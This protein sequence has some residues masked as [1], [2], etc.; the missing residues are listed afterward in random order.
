MK[1]LPMP[2]TTRILVFASL[3]F[4]CLSCSGGNGDSRSEKNGDSEKQLKSTESA[5]TSVS[6]DQAARL[7]NTKKDLLVIDVRSPR[8]LRQGRI[9]GSILIPFWNI[10]KGNHNLP[11][12][13][14]LLLVCAVGGRSFAVGQYLVRTGYEEIYN[15]S[16]GIESWKKSRYPVVY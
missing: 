6:V 11:E 14:P 8:E 9:A 10:L 16:G 5:F 12:E 7:I 13:R 2:V 1:I 15:M 3:L 4:L